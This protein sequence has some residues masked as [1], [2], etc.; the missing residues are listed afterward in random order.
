MKGFLVTQKI[1]VTEF[2]KSARGL[3]NEGLYDSEEI[4]GILGDIEERWVDINTKVNDCEEWLSEMTTK[5]K[6]CRDSIGSIMSF[7]DDGEMILESLA[8]FDGDL[9]S[10]LSQKTRLCNLENELNDLRPTVYNL[11]SILV[12]LNNV[13]DESVLY[14]LDKDIRELN[15]RY[16][17]VAEKIKNHKIQTEQ[18]ISACQEFDKDCAEVLAWLEYQD[19]VLHQDLEPEEQILA[20]ELAQLKDCEQLQEALNRQR[21]FFETVRNRGQELKSRMKQGNLHVSPKLTKLTRTFSDFANALNQKQERLKVKTNSWRE[22]C[23]KFQTL[24]ERVKESEKQAYT[25]RYC[26][27]KEHYRLLQRLIREAIQMR[28]ELEELIEFTEEHFR[29]KESEQGKSARNEVEELRQRLEILTAELD[30]KKT[31]VE[32]VQKLQAKFQE[33][34]RH[35]NAVLQDTEAKL[36]NEDDVEHLHEQEQSFEFFQS[37]SERYQE[38]LLCAQRLAET[39]DQNKERGCKH[40]R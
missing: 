24:D 21:E 23:A 26:D 34:C 22:F 33:Q 2:V 16:G 36:R 25:T 30:S 6:S 28:P 29:D 10:L 4:E 39:L 3:L 12:E 31:E 20:S 27:T 1:S 5:H 13:C 40:S 7:L 32:T 35:L 19:N 17:S 14:E 9:D 18:M 11:N 8:T 37:N 15:L 38:E